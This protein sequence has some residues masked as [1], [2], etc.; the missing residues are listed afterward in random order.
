MTLDTD[1]FMRR[2]L[3]HVLPRGFHRIRHYGLLSNSGRSNNIEKA[4]R[5]L[6]VA[7]LVS[8]APADDDRTQ[9]QRSVF[10]CPGCGAEMIVVDIVARTLP[11]RAPPAL[12]ITA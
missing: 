3:L 2:F 10:V 11:I 5:L 8:E 12:R 4:R 1:E 7:P 9:P 6:D